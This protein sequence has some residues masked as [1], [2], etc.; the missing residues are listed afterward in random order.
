MSETFKSWLDVYNNEYSKNFMV[1][2]NPK[3]MQAMVS[4]MEKNICAKLAARDYTWSYITH[5]EKS[6]AMHLYVLTSAAVETFDLAE[7]ELLTNLLSA[8]SRQE[9]AE[10]VGKGR[11]GRYPMTVGKFPSGNLL[12]GLGIDLGESYK[13]KGFPMQ[14][15]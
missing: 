9:Y 8:I 3:E 11:S 4:F 2:R 13:C 5:R 14:L 15:V 10:T 1:R 7:Q 6:L 12:D